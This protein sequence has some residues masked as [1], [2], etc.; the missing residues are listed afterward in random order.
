LDVQEVLS[1]RWGWMGVDGSGWEWMR[2][3]NGIQNPIDTYK[4]YPPYNPY[5]IIHLNSSGNPSHKISMLVDRFL[6]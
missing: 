1:E 3:G 6:S 2:E 5:T 4:S